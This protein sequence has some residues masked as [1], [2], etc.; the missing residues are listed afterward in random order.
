[1]ACAAAASDF[2]HAPGK[3]YCEGVVGELNFP[4]QRAV[5]EGNLQ[6]LARHVK[7]E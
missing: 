4:L 3:C 6:Y 2:A 1:M 5:F 7:G